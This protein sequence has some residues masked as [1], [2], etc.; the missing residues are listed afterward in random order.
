MFIHGVNSRAKEF[1]RPSAGSQ[2]FVMR[3]MSSMSEIMVMPAV[4]TR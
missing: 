4:G 1:S 3:R 2:I